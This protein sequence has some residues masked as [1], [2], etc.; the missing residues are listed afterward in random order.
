FSSVDKPL[1]TARIKKAKQEA[2]K[3]QEKVDAKAEAERQ[4]L[5]KEL[6]DEL[7]STL[8]KVPDEAVEEATNPLISKAV[9]TKDLS[10][11]KAILGAAKNA[12]KRAGKADHVAGVEAYQRGLEAS[13]NRK[14]LYPKDRDL[15]V[16]REDIDDIQDSM[17]GSKGTAYAGNLAIKLRS[18]T[19]DSEMKARYTR[20][21]IAR[22]FS[23]REANRAAKAAVGDNDIRVGEPTKPKAQVRRKLVQ[24]KK[25]VVETTAPEPAPAPKEESKPALEKETASASKSGGKLVKKNEGIYTL[26]KDDNI[27]VETYSNAFGQKA[28]SEGNTWVVTDLNDSD[29][30][31]FFK[32][33][34]R[35]EQYAHTLYDAAVERRNSKSKAPKAPQSKW[36]KGNK[37]PLAKGR[38]GLDSNSNIGV[39]DTGKVPGMRVIGGRKWEVIHN[40]MPDVT[41]FFKTL[42]EAME[43][44]HKLDFDYRGK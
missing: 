6:E 28:D 35:A 33:K 8:D 16:A 20:S 24:P 27:Y 15:W 3:A 37:I 40:D 41:K 11:S 31:G 18:I 13:L 14:M 4:K 9:N 39:R 22:K 36:E 7:N 17:S 26:E 30:T 12:L 19:G 25:R 23:E 32:S 29:V 42:E 21:E 10:T 5:A 1:E 2:F 38:Y 34:G 43:Y 44:A